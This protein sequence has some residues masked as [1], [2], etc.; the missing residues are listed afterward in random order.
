MDDR[1]VIKSYPPSAA[2]HRRLCRRLSGNP[3]VPGRQWPPVTCADDAVVAQGRVYLRA[4]QLTRKRHRAEQGHLL[5]G[6]TP[7]AEDYALEET[8]LAA[9]ADVFLA[10]APAAKAPPGVQ[11]GARKENSR[12][13]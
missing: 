10:R 7:D 5:S 9:V 3:S 6:A 2:G 8:G 1:G 12:A 11:S 4:L 13:A